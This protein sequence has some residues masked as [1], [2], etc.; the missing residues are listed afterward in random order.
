MKLILIFA[1]CIFV[2]H[3]ELFAE[4]SG[5]G[6]LVMIDSITTNK[7]Q[8]IVGEKISFKGT[9]RDP[10]SMEEY[11]IVWDFGNGNVA[12]GTL[13]TAENVYAKPGAY[14]VT[15]SVENSK[16]IKHEDSKVIKVEEK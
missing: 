4:N 10:G 15:F 11:S 13:A 8:Y 5:D 1:F 12:T 14:A 16:G 3:T 6:G 2:F 7:S 9:F